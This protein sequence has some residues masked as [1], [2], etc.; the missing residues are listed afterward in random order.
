ML[1]KCVSLAAR[2]QYDELA[3]ATATARK[4]RGAEKQC[5]RRAQLAAEKHKAG[6]AIH[7]KA[8]HSYVITHYHTMYH[9][10]YGLTIDTGSCRNLVGCLGGRFR[11][12]GTSLAIVRVTGCTGWKWQVDSALTPRPC[13]TATKCPAKA[14]CR[15]TSGNTSYSER[16]KPARVTTEHA[17]TH[18]LDSKGEMLSLGILHSLRYSVSCP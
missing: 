15:S 13:L 9:I 3:E 4:K 5:G 11:C 1:R 16:S 17:P 10:V 12:E 8:I 7:P 2:E 6:E 18:V 14:R